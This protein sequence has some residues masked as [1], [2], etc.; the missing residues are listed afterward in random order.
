MNECGPVATG[1]TLVG[2]LEYYCRE[3]DRSCRGAPRVG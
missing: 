2:K 1:N 3:A